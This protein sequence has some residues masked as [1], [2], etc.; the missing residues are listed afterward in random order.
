MSKFEIIDQV[1]L[2][3]AAEAGAA[4]A[5]RRKNYNFHDKDADACHRLLNAVE[6]DSYIPPHCH[7][8]ASKDET[9]LVLRGRIGMV[10]F[11]PD[12]EITSTSVLEAGGNRLGINIP[13]GQ[14]HTLVALEPGSVF[15]EA[16][17]GPFKPLQMEEKAT[18]APAEGEPGADEYLNKLKDLFVS[19]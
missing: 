15:F 7:L 8:D 11:N 10:I 17:A 4:A 3:R 19:L 18:W 16:K 1:L 14:F 5:R 9:I 13:H 6:P 12:G 2:Q